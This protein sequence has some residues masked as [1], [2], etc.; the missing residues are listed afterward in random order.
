MKNL[1]HERILDLVIA[2]SKNKVPCYVMP[3]YDGY[4][5]TFPWCDGDVIA[6]SGML[7]YGEYGYSV[8][9]FGFPWDEGDVT[10]LEVKEAA[11]LITSFYE[12]KG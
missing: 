3:L 4:K 7:G 12:L 10:L 9:S 1:Y 8:E 6:H 5:V 2:L 11:D